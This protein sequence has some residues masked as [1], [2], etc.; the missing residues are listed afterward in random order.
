M[1]CVR[2]SFLFAA[3]TPQLRWSIRLIS[4]YNLAKHHVRCR[5]SSS[6]GNFSWN[7]L[8]VG[9]VQCTTLHFAPY[10]KCSQATNNATNKF[11][12]YCYCVAFLSVLVADW[13]TLLPA[14]AASVDVYNFPFWLII[15]STHV[16]NRYKY[17]RIE[18]E[19]MSIKGTQQKNRQKCIRVNGCSKKTTVC[20]T[21]NNKFFCY[22]N[23][24]TANMSLGPY[25]TGVAYE[26]ATL[27]H[28][29]T[30]F[31][32]K[33]MYAPSFITSSATRLMVAGLAQHCHCA[34]IWMDHRMNGRT[35]LSQNVSKKNFSGLALDV[36]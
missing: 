20:I 35:F 26:H 7:P 11:S 4:N 17:W 23:K 13:L 30:L 3:V 6:S 12:I 33:S 19:R 31:G 32:G 27:F 36:I 29:D 21:I 22:E 18:R 5:R 1:H 8:S 28:C 14:V 16:Q 15:N 34:N 9:S 10:K 24:M 2:V 25:T